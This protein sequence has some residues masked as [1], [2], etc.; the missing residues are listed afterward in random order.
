MSKYRTLTASLAACVW[1]VTSSIS[2]AQT[3]PVTDYK[4]AAEVP[5]AQFFAL[6]DF[7]AMRLSPDGKRIAAV[8][9]Y[10]GRGNLIVLD[11]ATRQARSIT[12]SERWDVVR[13]RWIGNNRLYFTVADGLEATG[14]PRLKGAYT[15]NVDGTDMK[16]VFGYNESGG[17]RGLRIESLLDIEGGDSTLGYVSMRERSRDYV[18]VYKLDFRTMR[19][20]LLTFDTPGRIAQWEL[21]SERRPRVAVREEPR[22]AKGK[23]VAITFW[24]R[25]PSGGAW[26]KMF[27]YD[28]Y[29]DVESYSICGF[30]KDDR[31]LFVTARRGRDKSALWKYDTQ[32]KQFGD[33]VLDDPLVDLVC[34]SGSDENE[35]SGSDGGLLVDPQTKEVVGFQYQGDR[36]KKVYFK[37]GSEHERLAKMFASAVPGF[38]EFRFSKDRSVALVMSYSD[39]D[40]GTYYLFDSNKKQLEVVAKKR[41]WVKPELMAERKPILYKARDGMMIPAYITLPRGVPAKNLPLIVNIHG[42]P[43]VRGYYWSEWGRWPEAQFFASRGYAVLEPEPRASMGFGHKLYSAGFKQWGQVAQDDITDGALHLVKE[44]IVDRDRMCLHGGSYGGYASLQGLVREP[45][46]FKCAHS[47]VAVTDLGLMQTVA[48]SDIAENVK[49]DYL[50]NEFKI[51]VGDSKE[52][53]EMFQRFSPARNA[54]RIK[55][56]VMLTMGSD[57]VRVPLI[58]G[59]KMRDAMIKAG[60]PIEW[61]VYAE[62]GHGFNKEANVTDFYTRSLRFYDE[63]IGPNRKKQP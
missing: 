2:V 55:G 29:V 17:P 7:R 52:D 46:L 4:S 42:G 48:W 39:I 16:E 47:F 34:N 20:E 53:A 31:T 44:G 28:Y 12:A 27:Q 35:G 49:F 61:K 5:V 14:R 1:A 15:I 63:H 25:A 21:D 11:L 60:K 45:D 62:E 33:M 50:G 22:P 24:H 13:P 3:K 37:P 41:A 40:P 38:S 9:P 10:K 43:M 26:E 51:L 23:P 58:H 19:Y 6:E 54:D 8:A 18:D 57:D 36:P 56:A 59:E 30:D 32:T